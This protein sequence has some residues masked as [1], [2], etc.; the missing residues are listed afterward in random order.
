MSS[1]YLL[2]TPVSLFRVS[3]GFDGMGVANVVLGFQEPGI[4]QTAAL[5]PSQL[6]CYTKST[7]SHSFSFNTCCSILG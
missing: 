5:Q 2:L 4:Q 1:T 7:S 3:R 6:P